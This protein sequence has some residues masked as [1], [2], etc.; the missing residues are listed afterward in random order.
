ML[1]SCRIS[2][3][4]CLD[5]VRKGGTVLLFGVNAKARTELSQ[6]E[7][8][9]GEK[10]VLG[11]WLANATFPLAVKLLESGVIDFSPL[12]THSYPLESTL[13]GINMLRSGIG[14]EVMIDPTK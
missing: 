6:A 5:N 3:Q 14:I 2:L 9:T 1:G 8:T 12:V 11:T 7:I 10:K 4:T 13:E